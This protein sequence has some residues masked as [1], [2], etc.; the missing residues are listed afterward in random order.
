M[1]ILGAFGI[2]VGGIAFGL[3]IC[4]SIW[5]KVWQWEDVPIGKK[6][7]QLGQGRLMYIG[8]KP[9]FGAMY[10]DGLGKIKFQMRGMWHTYKNIED[11]EQL[12]HL[13]GFYTYGYTWPDVW[14]VWK[15][16]GSAAEIVKAAKFDIDYGFNHAGAQ[17]I[18]NMFLWVRNFREHITTKV[19]DYTAF[20]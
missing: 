15:G 19:A 5:Y 1:T 16:Y 9:G 3:L 13:K 4:F 10:Y 18:C 20:P 17:E 8:D 12:M 11:N 6:V 7:Y 14:T 2:I